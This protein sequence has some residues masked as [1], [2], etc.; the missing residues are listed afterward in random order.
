MVVAGKFNMAPQFTL[1][2]LLKGASSLAQ[3][4]AAAFGPHGHPV[5]IETA[6]GRSIATRSGL[7]IAETIR[8][9]DEVENTAVVLLAQAAR[10]T[11]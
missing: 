2:R 3:T 9:K 6:E 4:V 8:P 7:A 11:E 10:K 1:P 5:I